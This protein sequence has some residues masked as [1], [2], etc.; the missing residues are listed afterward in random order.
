MVKRRLCVVVL[1]AAIALFLHQNLVNELLEVNTNDAVVLCGDHACDHTSLQFSH[2]KS[3]CDGPDCTFHLPGG[4]L[5]LTDMRFDENS[6]SGSAFA[7]GYVYGQFVSGRVQILKSPNPDHFTDFARKQINTISNNAKFSSIDGTDQ[8]QHMIRG[9]L[10]KIQRQQSQVGSEAAKIAIAVVNALNSPAIKTK[11][12]KLAIAASLAKSKPRAPVQPPRL[13]VVQ[14]PFARPR[15]PV[16]P[17]PVLLLPPHP[18]VPHSSVAYGQWKAAGTP[19]GFSPGYSSL[20]P[21]VGTA[22][23]RRY[24]DIG[25][26]L[27]F[28]GLQPRDPWRAYRDFELGEAAAARG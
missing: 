22:S 17:P 15:P 24:M 5:K 20:A 3:K 25:S 8:S 13:P 1:P 7:S 16:G 2:F 4:S 19:I 26:A 28:G 18:L 23:R 10:N 27:A 11:I 21:V 14:R 6:T 12:A 9:V